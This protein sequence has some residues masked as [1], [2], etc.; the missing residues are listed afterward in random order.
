MIRNE[1]SLEKCFNVERRKNNSFQYNEYLVHSKN[2][3]S[4]INYSI[5]IFK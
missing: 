5:S 3:D 4:I 1:K 2:N